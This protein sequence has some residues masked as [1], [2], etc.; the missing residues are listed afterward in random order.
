MDMSTYQT[1][2]RGGPVK[3]LY[4]MAHNLEKELSEYLSYN[5]PEAYHLNLIAKMFNNLGSKIETATKAP[6]FSS[7]VKGDND[8]ELL[9]KNMKHYG[10]QIRQLQKEFNEWSEHT[11]EHFTVPNGDDNDLVGVRQPTN[12]IKISALTVW[13]DSLRNSIPTAEEKVNVADYDEGALKFPY[14]ADINKKVI[15]WLGDICNVESD[16]IVNSTNESMLDVSG[17]CGR[18]LSKGGP[19]LKEEIENLEACRTGEARLTKGHSLPA[20]YIIH[21]VGPRYNEKYR[22]AAENALHN[23]YRSSMQLLKEHNLSTMAFSVIN[24]EKRGYP[25]SSGAHV[26]IRT[27]RRFLEKWGTDI[28]RVVFCMDDEENFKLYKELLPLYCP[29]SKQEAMRSQTKLPKDTGNDLGETVV[30]ERKIRISAFPKPFG[31]QEEDESVED[32][33]SDSDSLLPGEGPARLSQLPSDRDEERRRRVAASTR[34]D[35]DAAMQ[36]QQYQRALREARETDLSDIARLNLLY[37]SG[38][39]TSGRPIMVFVAN[40]LPEN[41][42]EMLERVFLYII[43]QMDSIANKPYIMVYLHTNMGVR[44]RP[45]FAWLKRMYLIMDA[46]YGKNLRAFYILH[47]TFWLKVWQKIFSTFS[48]SVFWSKIIYLTRLL[49]LYEHVEQ[50]QLKIPDDIYQYDHDVYGSVSQS[51]YSNAR[52]A[53]IM[54]EDYGQGL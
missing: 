44:R 10:R 1:A 52:N 49:E 39:D 7:L 54:K 32:S 11:D 12:K 15:L 18:I 41:N 46:K 35:K 30:E 24:S 50:E 27:V 53:R 20:R 28:E 23:C 29:R 16:A 45:Q 13:E 3:E 4:I 21:T 6:E 40:R 19:E 42:Q 43:K 9:C 33:D 22:T 5:K 14:R 34:A 36:A 51:T 8:W 17:L 2:K 38:T 47:P 26:A 31:E 25:P 48:Q 37:Q